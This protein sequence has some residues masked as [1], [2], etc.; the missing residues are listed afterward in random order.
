MSARTSAMTAL[1]KGCM[2]AGLRPPPAWL[3]V[4]HAGQRLPDRLI[5]LSMR[6]QRRRN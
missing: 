6:L 2:L 5:W 1:S 4:Q 3:L